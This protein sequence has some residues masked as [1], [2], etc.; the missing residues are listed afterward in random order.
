MPSQ[1]WAKDFSVTDEDL[2]YLSGILLEKEI[3][4]KTDDLALALV[5]RRLEQEATALARQFADV[6]VYRPADSFAPDMLVMFPRLEFAMGRVES[7]RRGNN[8]ALGEFDVM[9]VVFDDEQSRDFAF[10]LPSHKLNDSDDAAAP[11]PGT[12]VRTAAEIMAEEGAAVVHELEANLR[13]ADELV[14][15]TGR[16]F[17]RSLMLD[18]NI[19]HLNLAEAVLD[20][21]GGGPMSVQELLNEIGGL[22]NAP[23]SLQQFSLNY[24]LSLDNRFDEVGPVDTVLWYLK[25]QE[26]PEVQTPPAILRVSPLSYDRDLLNADMMALEAEI[27]DEWSEVDSPAEN[28]DS[29]TLILNYPHRRAGTLPLNARLQRIFPTARRTPRIF[30]TLV[31]G[32]DGEEYP[33]WVVREHR[34]V[35][36]LSTL[37]RKHKLPVG[38]IIHVRRS[39]D[40]GKLVVGFNAHKPRTEYVPLV[41]ARDNRIIFAYDRRSIGAEYDDL[42]VLGVDDLTAV[43]AVV[44]EVQRSRRSLQQIVRDLVT[45]LSRTSPQGTVHAKTVYSAANLFRR[46][47]PGPV[48]AA[49]VD[50]A[51]LENVG[52]NYWRLRTI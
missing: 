27:D 18:A 49:L 17:P 20:I 8:A 37:F 2:D 19:G 5:E 41:T 14:S 26:P 6:R 28:P 29:A 15:V 33:C 48:F 1:P 52:S 24:A 31:D 21:N 42:M 43:D 30:V 32:Q 35:F 34:Y 40:G 39:P 44:A 22:G 23:A 47:P 46:L 16:W 50:S 10:N 12:E 51:E 25:R 36:G 45:E 13:A 9:R 11:L 3:P 4:L 7:I 38:A